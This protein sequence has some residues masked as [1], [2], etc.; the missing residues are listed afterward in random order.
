[1]WILKKNTACV[2]LVAL[3]LSACTPDAGDKTQSAMSHESEHHEK[4]Q[5][6]PSEHQN[7]QQ[8]HGD[9]RIAVQLSGAQRQH[10]LAEMRG[11][12][13]STQGIVE[14]LALGDMKLVQS[15]A[16]AAGM[17]GRKTTE[18]QIMHKKMPPE[19][20]RLG[21]SAHKSMDEIAAMAA[22]NMPAKDIQLKLVQ[23][24]NACIACHS[25]YYLPGQEHNITQD[26]Q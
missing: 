22:K 8:K 4:M 24:M 21:M 9:T 3:G 6:A 14:G 5:G 17:D 16:K 18:N 25:A 13:H 10:V 19:W 1:M 2:F 23:T 20:M 15:A 26:E 12:L 11:L 7:G